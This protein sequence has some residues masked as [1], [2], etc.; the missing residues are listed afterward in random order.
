M[1][2]RRPAIGIWVICVGSLYVAGAR[3]EQKPPGRLFPP[4]E[5]GLLEAPDRD[6]W[7][8]PDQVMDAMGIADASIVADVGA[9]E[10]FD[11]D[12]LHS[13]SDRWEVE[14]SGARGIQRVK[15]GD[16]YR[17]GVRGICRRGLAHSE[18]YPDHEGNLSFVRSP[19]AHHRLFNATRSIFVHGQTV[20]C[21]C[22][23]CGTGRHPA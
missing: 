13:G 21:R 6:I 23:D 7:Q 9:A 1:T 18:Q 2:R 4:Q 17:D 22:E 5:L 14:L 16:S 20:P 12:R 11:F 3:A 19:A 15:V 10:P 8:R